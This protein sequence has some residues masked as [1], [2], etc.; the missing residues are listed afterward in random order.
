M[1]ICYKRFRQIRKEKGFSQEEIASELGMK[2]TQ[3]SRYERGATKITLEFAVAFA[4]VMDC[5]LDYLVGL[6]NKRKW[7]L[8]F[9]KSKNF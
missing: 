3:Y 4:N 2:Q 5:S 6:T 9:K 1:S 7:P 8:I